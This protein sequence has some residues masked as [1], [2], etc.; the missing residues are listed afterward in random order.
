[1][2]EGKKKTA[3]TRP[4]IFVIREILECLEEGEG[5]ANYSYLL[6]YEPGTKNRA[7]L[8][9]YLRLL[10]E[11]GLI[12]EIK[13][14]KSEITRMMRGVFYTITNRGRIFL[15]LFPNPAANETPGEGSKEQN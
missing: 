2:T 9:L 14:E 3:L 7:D 15:S 1:M 12:E 13:G 5:L 11:L 6:E 8:V 4:N 10:R